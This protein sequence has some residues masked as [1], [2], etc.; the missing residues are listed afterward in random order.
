M[1]D[2]IT[3]SFIDSLKLHNDYVNVFDIK[4]HESVLWF[5][6]MGTAQLKVKIS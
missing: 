6:E 4:E 2:K 3:V 5:V 1:P